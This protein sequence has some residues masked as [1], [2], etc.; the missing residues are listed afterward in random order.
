[1]TFKSPYFLMMLSRCKINFFVDY[2]G[3]SAHCVM[4]Y[5]LYYLDKA[6][7]SPGIRILR[8]CFLGY[9]KPIV[10]SLRWHDQKQ[11]QPWRFRRNFEK[12]FELR[13]GTRLYKHFCH[14]R[15]SDR[16]QVCSISLYCYTW[17]WR[18]FFAWFT[19]HYSSIS[20]FFLVF[21]CKSWLSATK[22]PRLDLINKLPQ[23]L[24]KK[25]GP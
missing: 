7:I 24:G 8:A 15:N 16:A 18:F 21:C 14:W 13:S 3:I 11:F 25:P 23:C 5:S 20:H 12:L 1:M 19:S 17:L 9:D 2:L 4:Y 6:I 10:R 22:K